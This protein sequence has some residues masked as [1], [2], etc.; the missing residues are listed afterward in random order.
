MARTR[1]A[2]RR[3]GARPRSS[4]F[5]RSLLIGAALVLP[6][7]WVVFTKTMFD[8]F[9]ADAPPF[10]LVVPRDVDL[11]VHRSGLAG[12]MDDDGAGLPVPLVPQRWMSTLP[13]RDFASSTWAREHGVP[14]G[15]EDLLAPIEPLLTQDLGQLDLFADLLGEE[16]AIIG[17]EPWTAGHLAL[18]ARISTKGKLAVEAL[19]FAGVRDGV[20]AGAQRSEVVDEH[21]P[22]L[23]WWR[24][25]L[26][27]GTALHYFREADLLV[28]GTDASLV[29]DVR[30]TLGQSDQLSLGASRLY[31]DNL[32]PEPE[33][34]R[35]PPRFSSELLFDVQDLLR[36]QQLLPDLETRNEDALAN[37]L[38]RLVDVERL[39]DAV[40]RVAFDR[41]R[42]DVDLFV[43]SSSDGPRVSVGG[44]RGSD[45]F[46]VHERLRDALAL[47]PRGTAAVQVLDVELSAF[48][49][50]VVDGLDPELVKL[51]NDSIRDMVAWTPTFNVN[52]VSQLIA[53]LDRALEGGITLALRP[54]DHDI[55]AGAQPVPA[56]AFIVPL[57]DPNAWDAVMQAVINGHQI[58]GVQSSAMWQQSYGGTGMHKVLPLPVT[59]AEAL[60][61]LVLDRETLVFSTDPEFTL[62]IVEV[63]M[64]RGRAVA[65]EPGVQDLLAAFEARQTRA[66]AASWIDARGVERMLAPYAEW[67]ADTDSTLDHAVLRAEKR[68][69]ILRDEHPAYVD[70]EADL[71]A[72]LAAALDVQLDAHI[73]ALEAG[74]RSVTIPAAARRHAESVGWLGLLRQGAFSLR[75]GDHTVGLALH[76]ETVID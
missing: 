73:D 38:P 74:R 58:L 23:R 24:L 2:R 40:G 61:F 9:E 57:R 27:D 18:L 19:D 17:R 6:V 59:A 51:I 56:L 37:I 47:L 34:A 65:A 43:D 60:S 29:R 4:R 8:P 69:E 63:Y 10:R 42:I 16:V 12:D 62:E 28:A 13:W 33:G 75:L 21:Q 22:D 72:E 67:W 52:N 26:P 30:R 31:L 36:G 49:Q 54:L 35:G 66:N 5:T 55:P 68:R 7:L 1:R 70:R 20:L 14:A 71:P 32:P 39:R 46:L 53:E 48:L 41:R 45:T 76:L 50:T 15:V 25:D 11:Y 44:L 3:S 64:G